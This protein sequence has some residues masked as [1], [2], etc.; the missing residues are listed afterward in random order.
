MEQSLYL[1]TKLFIIISLLFFDDFARGMTTGIESEKGRHG[2]E[3][4]RIMSDGPN[5]QPAGMNLR[6]MGP[7]S[8][9]FSSIVYVVSKKQRMVGR[10]S[11]NFVPT[12]ASWASQIVAV[13]T[14]MF[15]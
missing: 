14:G 5:E 1:A 15:V 3:G 4:D 12:T 10:W 2:D 13:W 8:P 11:W 9:L 7:L 6:R